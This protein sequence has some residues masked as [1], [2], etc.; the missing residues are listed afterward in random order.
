MEAF[1]ERFGMEKVSDCIRSIASFMIR[2]LSVSMNMENICSTLL[3]YLMILD[4][5]CWGQPNRALW[6]QHIPTPPLLVWLPTQTYLWLRSLTTDWGQE[7]HCCDSLSL[8]SSSSNALHSVIES[9][10]C[11]RPWYWQ[12]TYPDYGAPC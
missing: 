8:L 7:P 4:E 12:E 6:K 5:R 9:S 3:K 1:C 10:C 2:I 11:H